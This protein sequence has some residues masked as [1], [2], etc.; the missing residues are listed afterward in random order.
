L[1]DAA[2]AFKED[3]LKELTIENHLLAFGSNDRPTL[4]TNGFLL[5]CKPIIPVC[6][7][8]YISSF[9]PLTSSL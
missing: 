2:T 7:E 3:A 6:L 8:S 1:N 9:A 4:L 5:P